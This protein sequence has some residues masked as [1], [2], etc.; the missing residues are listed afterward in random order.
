[1]FGDFFLEEK[2]DVILGEPSFVQG[3]SRK[4][5][6]VIFMLSTKV[7]EIAPAGYRI[8]NVSGLNGVIDKVNLGVINCVVFG[9][10]IFGKN[11]FLDRIRGNTVRVHN[12]YPMVYE[13]AVSRALHNSS[14]PRDL[15]PGVNILFQPFLVDRNKNLIAMRTTG[16]M[17]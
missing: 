11:L 17:F 8:F 1:L 12:I 4:R 9:A 13:L 14:V 2:G 16:I 3:C 5:G 10:L 7:S 6:F 15:F